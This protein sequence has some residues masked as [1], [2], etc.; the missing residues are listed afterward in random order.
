MKRRTTSILL[1]TLSTF[2]ALS[3]AGA[4]T[5]SAETSRAGTSLV[6]SYDDESEARA[7]IEQ[8]FDR[9][10]AGDYAA[11]YDSLPTASQRRISRARFVEGLSRTRGV[12]T[13]ERLEVERVR[14]AGNLAVVDST[15]YA[16][17]N[18][19]IQSEGKI[20]SRQYLVR[21]GGRWRVTT[22]DRSTVRPLLAAN[23][24]F[25]RQFPPTEPRVF[26]KRDGRWVGIETLVPRRKRQ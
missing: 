25:A 2:I 9:L 6:F 5:A 21:E 17:V 24:S 12:F 16:T 18:Q 1:I 15:L 3:H 14:V 10:R 4:P 22:G 26:L 23:P 11:V 19:P 7:A 8:A 20:V 13:L